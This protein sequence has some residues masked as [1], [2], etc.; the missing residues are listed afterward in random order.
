MTVL[1]AVWLLLGLI[2]L[3]LIAAMVVQA[4]RQRRAPR[5]NRGVAPG[6]GASLL[7]EGHGGGGGGGGYNRPTLVPRDPQAY[8]KA[9]QPRK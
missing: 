9:L 4:R 8:A 1:A 7:H 5:Q 6:Q 3:T 2:G